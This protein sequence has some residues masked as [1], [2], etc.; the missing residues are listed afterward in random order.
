[1]DTERKRMVEAQIQSRG[2]T[3][4]RVLQAFLT[5]PRHEFVP[6]RLRSDAYRD[7]PL[8]IGEGQTISQPYM[9]ASMTLAARVR[10]G[11]R[12][13]EIGT[14]SGYQAGILAEL[15]AEVYTVERLA[16]LSLAAQEVLSRLDYTEVH[17]KIANGTLG[18]ESQAPFAAIIVTAG[19]PNIPPPL[20]DQLDLSGRLVI[21]I[22]EGL[23]QVLYVVVKTESGIEKNR[24]ERCT[25]V[26]LLGEYGWEE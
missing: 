13:L 7:C 10:A 25:F 9:V 20:V 8:P 22:E 11:D 6:Q 15:G 21:P 24:G 2:I 5:V 26:P 19:A 16:S 14:G 3:D 12:V 4:S 17:F 1:M 18:W 23:S